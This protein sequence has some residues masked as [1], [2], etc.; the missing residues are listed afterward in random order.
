M[1]K[2]RPMLLLP[3]ARCGDVCN[4]RRVVKA[5]SFT[6]Q[7]SGAGSWVTGG[8]GGRSKGQGCVI[9]LNKA[10]AVIDR[11]DHR[12]PSLLYPVACCSGCC[13]R[14]VNSI[15]AQQ[16]GGRTGRG[17]LL[18]GDG[19]S[20]GRVALSCSTARWP[21]LTS[22]IGDGHRCCHR[23]HAAVIFTSCDC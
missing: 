3:V 9:L 20:K 18:A 13:V 8:R 1:I 11:F 23:S 17:K 4:L 16:D 2:R 12:R 22:S 6:A 7:Q 21:G 5:D 10:M 14:L 15:A 19:K